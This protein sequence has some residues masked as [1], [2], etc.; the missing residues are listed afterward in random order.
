MPT[1]AIVDYGAGNLDSVARALEVSGGRPVLVRDPAGLAGATHVVLPGVG[2]FGAGIAGLRARGYEDALRELVVGRR[3]PVL[4]ICLGMQLL[5]SLG[6]E[7]IDVPGLGWVDG[8]VRRLVPTSPSEKV[9]H[10]GWNEVHHD[11]SSPLFRGI[12]SGRTFYFVHSYC[13]EPH[14]PADVAATTPHCGGFVSAVRRGHVLGVQ[15][16][17][18]KSQRAGLALLA[19]FLL[20]APGG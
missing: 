18:E 19:N 6:T 16:H 12:A 11:G 4:G 14:D 15:F 9:P 1:V 2:S 7:P 13:F 20:L 5:A 10:V 3:I 8:T 17:P